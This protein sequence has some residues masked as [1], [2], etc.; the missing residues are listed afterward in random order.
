[1]RIA[2]IVAEYNPFHSGHRWHIEQTRALGATHIV[3]VM[4]GCYLQRGEPALWDKWVRTRAALL[5]GAD[6]ILELPL[7]YACATAQQFATGA[8]S[9]LAALGAVELLSF[10]SECGEAAPLVA[11]ANAIL[12]SRVEVTARLLLGEGISYAVARQRAVEQLYGPELSGLLA[13]PN[14]ILG[15]E[16]IAALGRLKSGIT[17]VT[18]RRAGAAHDGP[19]VGEHASASAL[20]GM[21]RGGNPQAASDYLLP[22][23]R[24]LYEKAW[25]A[26]ECYAPVLLERPLLAALRR[27]TAQQLAAL[28]DIAEG[29][30]NRICTALRTATGIEDLLDAVKTKRYSHARLR[31]ILL[32]GWLGVPSGMGKEP[33]PYIRLLGMNDRGQEIL[34]RAGQAATLPIS[35]SLARL[36]EQGERQAAFARL[37]AVA[38]DLYGTIT[39][40]VQPCGRDY[41]N[42]I[43]KV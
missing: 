2:G 36:G 17:P 43:I 13:A 28:P 22:Q 27:M 39:Q 9:T 24:D 12:D 4:S 14:N 40:Q 25:Q 15:I 18:V 6:L 35:H 1:M 20:R 29:L 37:E 33:P 31:R 26:G 41:T 21:F 42:S 23:C 7:P 30:E 16:Y 3:V 19:A 32:C 34:A 8:V 10:G 38:D 5:G 11:A